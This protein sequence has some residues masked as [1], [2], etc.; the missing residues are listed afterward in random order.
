MV[1][2]NAASFW[3]G[4]YRDLTRILDIPSATDC[5]F[6]S[7]RNPGQYRPAVRTEADRFRS[8]A[9][10]TTSS[11]FSILGNTEVATGGGQE[12]LTAGDNSRVYQISFSA[13]C[14]CLEVVAVWSIAPV[15]AK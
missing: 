3:A 15:E 11:S 10:R 1:R 6:V 14:I 4:S 8:V 7:I 12:V 13:N 5:L 9:E 2:E